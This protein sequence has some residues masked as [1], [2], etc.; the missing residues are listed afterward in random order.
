[1]D[2]NILKE[3]LSKGKIIWTAHM[4]TRLHERGI[5][6]EDVRHCI[7]SGEIIEENP[8]GS[9][10]P[11]VLIYG[12]DLNG[13]IIHVFCGIDEDYLYLVTTYIPTI[14]KF[15][16]DLKTRRKDDVPLLQE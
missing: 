16:D 3:Y 8:N 5:T 15:L 6:S 12:N 1:M 14:E 2:I 10:K 11:N 9:P 4:L 7:M 13:Q